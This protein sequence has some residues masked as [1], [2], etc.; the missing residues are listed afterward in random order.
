[1]IF[2]SGKLAQSYLAYVNRSTYQTVV[3]WAL[4]RMYYPWCEGITRFGSTP[5]SRLVIRD[6]F[7]TCQWNPVKTD[8]YLAVWT[9][10]LDTG[11][12]WSFIAIITVL[13]LSRFYR[14]ITVWYLTRGLPNFDAVRRS[15]Q[16]NPLTLPKVTASHGHPDAAIERSAATRHM[17]QLFVSLG[18][19]VCS[20]QRS[21]SEARN[22]LAGSL[23]YYWPTDMKSKASAASASSEIWVDVDHYVDIN[24]EF[25]T[26]KPRFIYTTSPKVAACS[27][28]DFT[29]HW[30]EEGEIKVTTG[31]GN[32]YQHKIWDYS[33]DTYTLYNFGPWWISW[34]LR[35]LTLPLGFVSY[36]CDRRSTSL[37]HSMVLLTPIRYSPKGL[38]GVISAI[39]TY[40]LIPEK[41][42]QA[43]DPIIRGEN[44]SWAHWAVMRA[45][46]LTKTVAMC[47]SMS[48]ATLPA[49]SFDTAVNHDK[50]TAKGSSPYAVSECSQHNGGP[51]RLATTSE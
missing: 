17:R 50:V 22:G 15:I 39:L 28:G 10:Y 34:L 18:Y 51:E 29:W 31:N 11:F 38:L 33:S 26:P 41:T 8:P 48:C 40:P 23:V 20:V 3:D 1:M 42:F 16:E 6:V 7:M 44:Y 14:S 25:T 37:H 27:E 4:T 32:A 46:Q 43:H 21:A 47:G 19:D 9:Q 12:A 35:I 45:G 36:A 24:A 5:A 2:G 13:T 49:K 30:T